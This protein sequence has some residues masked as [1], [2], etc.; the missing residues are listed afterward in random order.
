MLV[1]HI[2]LINRVITIDF[3]SKIR[4]YSSTPDLL[5]KDIMLFNLLLEIMSISRLQLIELLKS[6]QE[7]RCLRRVKTQKKM[8][9][10]RA[11]LFSYA[12]NLH[13]TNTDY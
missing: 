1:K 11:A 7:I 8:H 5:C 6:L 2:L 9:S 10:T 4:M 12:T 13:L 3:H